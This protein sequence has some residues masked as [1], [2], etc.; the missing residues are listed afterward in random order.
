MSN[1]LEIEPRVRSRTLIIVEGH[2]EKNELF[3]TIFKCFP[4]MHIDEDD[5]WIYGTN[6][7]SLYDS[8]VNEYGP[9][10]NELDVDLPLLVSREL[11]I[12]AQ[13]KTMFKNI[14][15][16]FDYERHDPKFSTEKIEKM[17]QY[18]CDSTDMGKLY[19]NYPMIES[20]QDLQSINDPTF[21]TLKVPVTL[22]PGT[23]YK[24]RVRNSFFDFALALP[25]KIRTHLVSKC[26]FPT[27]YV[28]ETVERILTLPCDDNMRESLDGILSAYIAPEFSENSYY[29]IRHIL[30]SLQ[31]RQGEQNYWQYLRFCFCHA[32]KHNIYKSYLISGGNCTLD[33]VECRNYFQNLS[34]LDILSQQNLLSQDPVLGEI[35]VLN[36]CILLVPEYSY[37]LIQ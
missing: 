32:I 23:K 29:Y 24:A 19:L 14:I 18:F 12:A 33:S 17:Q 9:D 31:H 35:W 27:V 2:H 21:A 37:D 7:Y 3:H 8:L 22:R 13:H 16:V 4:E 1:F 25:K 11:N 15:L 36:T 5:V 6:I 28:D 30:H 34:L 10:W 20:Y 26:A